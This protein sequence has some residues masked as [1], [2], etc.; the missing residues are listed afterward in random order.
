MPDPRFTPHSHTLE[1]LFAEHWPMSIGR[2]QRDYAWESDEV[3]DFITDLERLIKRRASSPDYAHF[4]GAVVVIK[5][6]RKDFLRDTG[7]V[8]DGQQRLATFSMTMAAIEHAARDLEPDLDEERRQ[9]SERFRRDLRDTF[10]HAT[11]HNRGTLADEDRPLL[12]LATRDEAVFRSLL[13]TGNLASG[14]SRPSHK[15]LFRAYE[16]IRR[17]LV[18]RQLS[19]EAAE[20]LGALKDLRT[21]VAE[22]VE[23]ILIETRYREHAVQLFSVLN[24][25][26]RRLEEADLLRVHT[27]MLVSGGSEDL[28]EK[29]AALWDAIDQ[30]PRQSVDALLRH[31]YASVVGERVS[32]SALLRQYRARFFKD[33]ESPLPG[34]EVS[35]VWES[36]AKLKDSAAIYEAIE[37]GRWPFE[38]SEGPLAVPKWERDRLYRLV[39]VIGSQRV[40]PV[41]LAAAT[42]GESSFRRVVLTMERLELR[43]VVSSVEQN[44]VANLYFD[45]AA[46]LRNGRMSVDDALLEVETWLARWA[47]DSRFELGLGSLTYS[48]TGTNIIKHVLTTID[49]QQ[50]WLRSDD[51]GRP[52]AAPMRTWDFGQ[53]QDEH[54]YPQSPHGDRPEDLEQWVH[55]LGNQTF[56]G[57]SDNR[58]AT[59]RLPTDS[60][61]MAAYEASESALTREVGA[62]VRVSG[63]WSLADVED[64]EAH[65]IKDAKR[66]FALDDDAVKKERKLPRTRSRL[67]QWRDE[68]IVGVWLFG[69]RFEDYPRISAEAV[70][71][72]PGSTPN[73]RSIMSG[74][75]LIV[76]RPA[77][78]R[79]GSPAIVGGVG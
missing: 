3:N 21:A 42:L 59:N 63:R 4:L 28:Q 69:A 75:Y 15:L 25:R 11:E 60:L 51:A 1:R 9:A 76:H 40:F 62:L 44:A 26:G 38:V 39:R 23:F 73:G 2:Y 8:V 35:R 64:R 78:E 53:V 31:H 66:V 24:N 6:H 12:S 36:L 48:T 22:G 52:K 58:A 10:I 65:L 19:G 50:T 41:L 30:L 34:A 18:D 32:T 71:E 72:F 43:A 46:L 7:E 56:W 57:P 61:K 70:Y 68:G 17:R 20:R 16:A 67:S 54:I 79:L 47:N 74:D 55:R 5:H 49:D 33:D 37:A 77:I 29:V 27:L 45:V 13:D 14:A